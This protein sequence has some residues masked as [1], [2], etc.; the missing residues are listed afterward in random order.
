[1]SKSYG[2]STVAALKRKLRPGQQWHCYNHLMKVDMGIRPVQTVR[3]SSVSFLTTKGEDKV[4]SWMDFPKAAQYKPH[5][6]ELGFDVL[7]DDGSKLLTYRL[8]E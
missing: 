2:L 7:N 1:M 3:S 4:E 6:D 5:E 8:I